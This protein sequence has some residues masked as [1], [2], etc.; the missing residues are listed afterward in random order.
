MT[1]LTGAGIAPEVRIELETAIG[2]AIAN[3]IE[4]GY[5]EAR[6]FQ[7]RCLIRAGEI[8]TEVEDD[9]TGFQMQ[10]TSPP[11]GHV[12]GFGFGIMRSLVDEL[13][14]LKNGRL[15]RFTKRL[16]LCH[17]ERST[18]QSDVRSRRTEAM[19]RAE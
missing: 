2:E 5:P 10:T 6:W 18:S 7:I 11:P 15:I 12:R 14:I 9:G 3:A 1:Y 17:P 4:H 13:H 16:P 8:V 19:L